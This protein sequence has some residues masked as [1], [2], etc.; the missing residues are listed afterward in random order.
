VPFPNLLECHRGRVKGGGICL[1]A[2]N[3]VVGGARLIGC[4]CSVHGWGRGSAH[5]CD[6]TRDKAIL[7]QELGVMMTRRCCGYVLAVC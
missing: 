1:G 3:N 5:V 6:F 7:Q 4:N 2:G